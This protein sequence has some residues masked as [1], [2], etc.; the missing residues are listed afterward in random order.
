MTT[1]RCTQKLLAVM[2]VAHSKQAM[3][4]LNS[5]GTNRL[6]DWSLNLLH[7]R[8]KLVVAVCEHGRLGL[9]LAAAPYATLPQR[10]V[11]AVHNQLLAIGVAPELAQRECDAM[12]HL[13]ITPTT[14]YANRL[15]L[16]AN[17]KD[18]GWLVEDYMAEGNYSLTIINARLAESI[19]GINGKL[20]FP[21]KFVRNLLL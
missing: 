15:S 12:Q 13:T 6:G 21:N 16:Q 4:E 2:K 18:Y 17:L 20:D 7:T 10:F 19:V 5:G 9:V 1:L 11:A 3:P 14:P 8:P